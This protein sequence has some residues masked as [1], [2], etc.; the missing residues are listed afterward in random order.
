MNERNY[1]WQRQAIAGIMIFTAVFVFLFAPVPSSSGGEIVHLKDYP[2][3]D[4][5]IETLRVGF[6][7]ELNLDI[8]FWGREYPIY[9]EFYAQGDKGSVEVIPGNPEMGYKIW[10]QKEPAP[11]VVILPGTAVNF[12]G[13]GPVALAQAG[14]TLCAR[15]SVMGVAWPVSADHT[16][17]RRRLF[18]NTF[19]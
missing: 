16:T 9:S 19:A 10:L 14:D 11:I 3:Q 4:P 1:G 17:M 6:F 2:G 8:S 12:D 13:E 18:G 15:G 7:K 5:A